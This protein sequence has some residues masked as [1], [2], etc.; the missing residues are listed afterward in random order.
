MNCC[1][2]PSILRR[3]RVSLDPP[4]HVRSEDVGDPR[5][6]RRSRRRT[7]GG[8]SPDWLPCRCPA[9][10]SAPLKPM[11]RRAMSVRSRVGGTHSSSASTTRSISRATASARELAGRRKPTASGHPDRRG[12]EDQRA[13]YHRQRERCRPSPLRRRPCRPPCC[14]AGTSLFRPAPAA[15]SSRHPCCSCS[16]RPCVRVRVAL[17][18][19][20]GAPCGPCARRFRCAWSTHPAAVAESVPAEVVTVDEPRVHAGE[21]VRR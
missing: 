13:G 20:R 15:P 1:L 14:V 7:P 9:L 17:H 5:R 16:P 10:P 4:H 18:R 19:W 21:E 3:E 6:C 2:S 12:D 11:A 8:S